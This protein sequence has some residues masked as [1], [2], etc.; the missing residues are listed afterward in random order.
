MNCYCS[1]H[2]HGVLPSQYYIETADTGTIGIR[3]AKCKSTRMDNHTSHAVA[4][5]FVEHR[6]SLVVRH[7]YSQRGA[8]VSL[9][10]G[11]GSSCRSGFRH[12]SPRHRELHSE[13]YQF[14]NTA[15]FAQ[16][17]TVSFFVTKN[18]KKTDP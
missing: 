4:G 6:W 18:K 7:E 13:S 11:T 10:R 3:M 12:L 17:I 5:I 2:F 14:H 15:I 16:F 1:C 8:E 9:P